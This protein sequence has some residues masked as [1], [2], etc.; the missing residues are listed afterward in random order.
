MTFTEPMF[1]P[2]MRFA[3]MDEV[4]VEMQLLSYTCPNSYWAGP[5]VVEQVTRP[6]TD[7]LASGCDHWPGAA[8]WCVPTGSGRAGSCWAGRGRSW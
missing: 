2:E 7:H 1:D 5:D 4:G 8:G 3:P 6:L